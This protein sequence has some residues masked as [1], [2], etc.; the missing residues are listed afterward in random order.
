MPGSVL[1]YGGNLDLLRRHIRDEA[2]DFV[3][4]DPPFNRNPE[5]NVRSAGKRQGRWDDEGRRGKPR[6]VN[7]TNIHLRT[8]RNLAFLLA[9]LLAGC[10]SQ[11]G[12]RISNVTEWRS[13][14]ADVNAVAFAPDG[15]LLAVGLASGDIV[16][17][18]LTG[19]GN[20]LTLGG[21]S[22]AV[23][24]LAFSPDGDFLA[25]VGDD[26][27][28]RLWSVN[29]WRESRRLAL[30]DA[31]RS[32][33]C[34]S[35]PR[36]IVGTKTGRIELW[37]PLSG[38]RAF[39]DVHGPGAIYLAATQGILASGG[40]DRIVRFW[41][42]DSLRE[43]RDFG[44]YGDSIGFVALS[45]DTRY[46]AIAADG[47]VEIRDRARMRCIRTLQSAPGTVVSSGRFL[48][49]IRLVLAE[50]ESRGGGSRLRVWDSEQ[51]RLLGEQR[52]SARIDGIDVCPGRSLV[53]V[54]AGREAT[55]LG[56]EQGN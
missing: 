52:F 28:V 37:Y 7:M 33:L 47:T 36:V 46:A 23:T 3:C 20:P 30:R 44:P 45:D 40:Y 51:G 34:L 8:T 29:G 9:G 11:E 1:D 13:D 53:A 10:L 2:V 15:S 35:G 19:P 6:S 5:C 17:L 24:A 55:V 38:R 14:R 31:G 16:I 39:L 22:A 43:E 49:E 26:S 18:S 27:L 12:V 50:Q 41:S 48:D 42:L 32:L 56:I 21:H 54:A 25:S 4:L